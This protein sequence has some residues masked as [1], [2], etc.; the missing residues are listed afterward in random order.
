MSGYMVIKFHEVRSK[1][2]WCGTSRVG[3]GLKLLM[4]FKPLNLLINPDEH[5]ELPAR[6]SPAFNVI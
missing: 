4:L 6:S 3:R 2:D 5:E 1:A